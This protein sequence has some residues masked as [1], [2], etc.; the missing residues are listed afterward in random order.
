M[1]CCVGH[2]CGSDLV[3]L[4]LWCRLAATAAIGPLVWELQYAVG[5]ALKN[6]KNKKKRVR[7]P[8]NCLGLNYLRTW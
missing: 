1:S 3:L 6:K 5:V 7:D 4:W 2:R 8:E